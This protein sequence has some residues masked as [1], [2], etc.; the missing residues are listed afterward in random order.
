MLFQEPGSIADFE[1]HDPRM[2]LTSW[3]LKGPVDDT[4]DRKDRFELAF[5]GS[6]S[7]FR[8]DISTE[9]LH[10]AE[11]ERER[12]LEDRDVPRRQAKDGRCTSNP[13]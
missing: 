4:K 10:G 5:E 6:I 12:M 7:K 3:F 2:W 9:Y 11:C 1:K 13:R 8:R